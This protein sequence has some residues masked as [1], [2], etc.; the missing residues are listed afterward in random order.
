MY[1]NNC[2]PRIEFTRSAAR[3]NRLAMTNTG[4]LSNSSD[5]TVMTRSESRYCRMALHAP[6]TTPIA[7]PSTEPMTSK[8]QADADAAPQLVGH[9]LAGDRRAE[10]AAHRAR[11]PMHVTERDRLVQVEFGGLGVDHRPVAA[12]GCAAP[13]CPAV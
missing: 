11:H 13:G 2:T 3:I 5:S 9:R 12:A 7:V 8:P 6:M 10:V 4:V 1:S